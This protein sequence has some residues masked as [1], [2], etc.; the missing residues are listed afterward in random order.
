[1]F[2]STQ[3]TLSAPHTSTSVVT[4]A[5]SLATPTTPSHPLS[6]MPFNST[7]VA[8]TPCLISRSCTQALV[9]HCPACFG[10]TMFGKPLS[11]GGDIHVSTDGNFHHWHCC[12]AGD[13]P[14]FYDPAYFLPKIQVDAMG[15]HIEKQYKNPAKRCNMMTVPDE[16]I[17]SCESLYEAT[18]GKK[19]KT[20]ME[21]FDNTGL[22]AFIC[23][24]DIPLFF[25]NID[26]PGEQQKYVLSPITHLFTLLLPNATVTFSF[27]SFLKSPSRHSLSL[28]SPS[29]TNPPTSSQHS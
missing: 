19:Q 4:L 12:S 1:M 22:M 20:S 16:A 3:S 5:H 8:S 15:Q 17:D 13:C 14:P 28:N 25:A 23:C 7:S 10:R 29:L 18:N 27:P 9:Q 6:N 11:E 21:S 24:Y 26:T 2:R